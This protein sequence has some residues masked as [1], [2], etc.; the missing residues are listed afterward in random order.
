MNPTF[1]NNDLTQEPMSFANISK[2][3]NKIIVEALFK[4]ELKKLSKKET[5]ENNENVFSLIEDSLKTK[6]SPPKTKKEIKITKSEKPVETNQDHLFP[7]SSKDIIS[8]KAQSAQAIFAPKEIENNSKQSKEDVRKLLKMQEAEEKKAEK[9]VKRKRLLKRKLLVVVIDPGHGGNDHG[10]TGK[11]Y[12][13]KEKD[14]TLEYSLALKKALEE[15]GN[16]KIYLTRNSDKYESL[17]AR[18]YKARTYQA[19]IFISLHADSNPD[20]NMRGLSVY[21]LSDKAYDEESEAL[22]NRENKSEMIG[23]LDLSKENKDIANLLIDLIKRDTKNNSLQFAKTVTTELEGQVKMIKDAHR[24]ADFKVLHGIDIPALLVEL[25]YVSNKEEEKLL[26]Q[27]EYKKIIIKTLTTA[28]NKFFKVEN[29]LLKQN[30]EN[31]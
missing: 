3:N 20:P 22:S 31:N 5:K 24:F 23:R 13:T 19:D 8:S 14:L 9:I 11:Y 30:G 29:K 7:I 25:G 12:A 6:I 26:N 21:T 1:L 15:T 17:T 18:R 10:A 2:Q 27:T 4:K 16:Y 28:I